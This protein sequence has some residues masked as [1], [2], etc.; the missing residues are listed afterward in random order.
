M[1]TKISIIGAGSAVF[2]LS[3]IRD[4]CLTPNLNGSIISFMD[5]DPARL[6]AAHALCQRYADEMGASLILEKTTDRHASLQGADFVVNAALAAGHHRLR[7]GWEIARRHGYRMGGSLHIVHDEAFWINFYQ[8]RLFES[9]IEDVLAICP[10]ALYLQIANPVLA[11][12][13]HLG[14]KYPQAKIAGLCHGFS[15]VYRLA[16]ALGLDRHQLTF[17]I[18]GVNHFVWLNE[19]HHNGED[20]FPLIDQW[21]AS[22]AGRYGQTCGPSDELGPKAVDLYRRLGVFPIGDTCTPGGGSWPWWYHTD[23]ATEA[24]WRE[25]PAGWYDGYFKA[26]ENTVQWIKTLSEDPA[27]HVTEAIP[28]EP[29]GEVVIPMIEAVACDIPRTLIGNIPNSGAFVP[30]VPRDV[31][32][33]IPILVDQRGLRG[34]LT[35]PLPDA[36][37]ALLLRDRVAPVELELSAYVNG[38]KE[39]LR[40]LIL[41][42]PYTRSFDQADA[43]LDEI[44]ALP[45]HAEMR[46]HYH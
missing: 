16:G 36:V 24:R 40:Q 26:L 19:L 8:Y 39:T 7:A 6:N 2:S 14:R 37:Q 17:Q 29:S 4:L 12:I 15:G 32:V 27:A 30:G 45:Y 31:A 44:L 43:L 38:G 46:Q 9:V 10:D 13:T 23:A 18:P 25:D 11:G 41:A 1:P 34:C 35:T 5:I 28:P 42:D 33:E 21:I 22:Q 3:L 20:V